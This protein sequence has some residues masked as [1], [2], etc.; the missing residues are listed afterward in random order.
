MRRAAQDIEVLNNAPGLQPRRAMR[1]KMS[2]HDLD[3]VSVQRDRSR[4]SAISHIR[5]V[6]SSPAVASGRPSG[7]NTTLEASPPVRVHRCSPVG[8]VAA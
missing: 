8:Q 6:V 3:S 4:T 2:F 7:L 1:K 5:T